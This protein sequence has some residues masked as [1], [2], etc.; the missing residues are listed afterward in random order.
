MALP[1]RLNVYE[2]KLN[3]NH[4]FFSYL[5]ESVIIAMWAM[6]SLLGLYRLI[7][8]LLGANQG[9]VHIVPVVSVF[10]LKDAI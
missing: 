4:T 10:K 6:T 1:M 3:N 9:I 7:Q 2:N 5:E 8:R